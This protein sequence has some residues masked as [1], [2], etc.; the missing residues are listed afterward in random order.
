MVKDVFKEW[1]VYFVKSVKP[2]ENDPVLLVLDNYG[3][4]LDNDAFE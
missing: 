2:T 1:C 4:H 3:G